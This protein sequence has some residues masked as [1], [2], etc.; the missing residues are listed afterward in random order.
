MNLSANAAK[1]SYNQMDALGVHSTGEGA[2][3]RSFDRRKAI[4]VLNS[5]KADFLDSLEGAAG[6]SPH[7]PRKPVLVFSCCFAE[8]RQCLAGT[9]EAGFED[10]LDRSIFFS[11]LSEP[12]EERPPQEPGGA[13]GRLAD[14]AVAAIRNIVCDYEFKIDARRSPRDFSRVGKIG[15][16]GAIFSTLNPDRMPAQLRIDNYFDVIGNPGGSPKGSSWL[17]AR[18]KIKDSAFRTLL[19]ASSGPA[20]PEDPLLKRYKPKFPVCIF[21]LNRL[22]NNIVWQFNSK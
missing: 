4:K 20:A 10:E 6:R 8:F 15:F 17:E 5:L 13:G 22:H 14:K 7:A 16:E 11:R 1:T 19:D 21:H 9:G 3:M 18:R 2:A 12:A